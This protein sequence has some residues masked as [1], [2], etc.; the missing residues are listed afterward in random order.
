MDL[1]NVRIIERPNSLIVIEHHNTSELAQALNSTQ[2]DRWKNSLGRS[3]IKLEI[4]ALSS[5]R[6]FE[7][8]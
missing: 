2:P 5:N 8:I 1:K 3:I 7:A 6:Q 4:F